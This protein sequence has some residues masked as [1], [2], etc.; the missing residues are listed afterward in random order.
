M[1]QLHS[2]H[3]MNMPAGAPGGGHTGGE[4][5][6]QAVPSRPARGQFEKVNIC[7]KLLFDTNYSSVTDKLS[8]RNLHPGLYFQKLPFRWTHPESNP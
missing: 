8:L 6:W 3:K 5:G 4:D 2:G 7:N 1:D